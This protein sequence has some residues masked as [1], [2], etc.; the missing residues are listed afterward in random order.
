MRLSPDAAPETVLRVARALARRY[1]EW[2]ALERAD[3]I[4]AACLGFYEARDRWRGPGRFDR[5][6]LRYM[7]LAIRAVRRREARQHP[8]W[9]GR[10]RP[11]SPAP[12]AAGPRP[13]RQ[14]ENDR[15]YYYRHTGLQVCD[16]CGAQVG[17]GHGARRCDACATPKQCRDRAFRARRRRLPVAA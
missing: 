13:V 2:G 6:A 5:Y 12:V 11:A 14:R 4:G 10:P 1:D 17:R 9:R 7:A 16:G 8:G 15:T 3:Y